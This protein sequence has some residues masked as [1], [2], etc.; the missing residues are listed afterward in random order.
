MQDIG[1]LEIVASR[2][3]AGPRSAAVLKYGEHHRF[4]IG[5]AVIGRAEY[6]QGAK[7][8]SPLQAAG[9]SPYLFED[10]E[11]TAEL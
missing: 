2:L 1:A 5:Q 9:L 10:M 3:K 7:R 6:L 8:K 4:K 11:E